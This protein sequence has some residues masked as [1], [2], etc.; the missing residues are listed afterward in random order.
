MKEYFVIYISSGIAAKVTMS[1][2]FKGESENSLP[3]I[4][5]S[6]TIDVCIYPVASGRRRLKVLLEP[7]IYI[8]SSW[9]H[10][11]KTATRATTRCKRGEW[12]V[13]MMVVWCGGAFDGDGDGRLEMPACPFPRLYSLFCCYCTSYSLLFPFQVAAYTRLRHRSGGQEPAK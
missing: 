1:G 10:S 11:K 2:T 7:K 13:S 4:S 5:Y 9:Y 12:Q 3:H 6:R 8:V